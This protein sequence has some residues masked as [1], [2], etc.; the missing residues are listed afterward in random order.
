[1][2]ASSSPADGRLRAAA[3]PLLTASGVGGLVL[4][5][6]L[7]DPHVQ[8]SWGVCSLYAVTGLYC[9]GCGGLRAVNDLTNF[10]FAAA[11][12]SNLLIYPIAVLLVWLWAQWL[13]NRV[14][15]RVPSLPR[16]KWLWI[17]LGALAAVWTVARNFP[18]S[19]FAP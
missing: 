9:P 2:T 16:N 13:G 5:L 3:A 1:M 18:G 8:N 4:A 17:G 11:F 14:G 12:S 6:H 15:F 7:R 10:D 19:P